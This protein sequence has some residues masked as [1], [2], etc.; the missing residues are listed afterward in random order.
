MIERLEIENFRGLDKLTIDGLAR[1][2][3]FVG[4]NNVG[5]SSVLEAVYLLHEL[6]VSNA[7]Q[8]VMQR[9]RYHATTDNLVPE[10][11][12]TQGSKKPMRFKATGGGKS[13][14]IVLKPERDGY[15]ATLAR[16]PALEQNVTAAYLV[17]A[18]MGDQQRHGR[19]PA[20]FFDFATL[21]DT[22]VAE[23]IGALIVKRRREKLVAALQRLDAR[24]VGI[25]QYK[26]PKTNSV[27]AWVDLGLPELLRLTQAGHGL[28][29]A[30]ALFTELD[31]ARDSIVL[32]DEFEV[33][34]H[35]DV[36]VPVW[37]TIDTLSREN[38][39]QL[40]VT[41]HSY[42]C[43]KAVHE[44][45]SSDSKDLAVFRLQRG[46]S[47]KVVAVKIDAKTLGGV[48]ALDLEVR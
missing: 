37:Q 12:Q 15:T 9:R 27:E 22:E 41:T 29:Y 44:A 4:A 25:D 21:Q 17:G 2:N 46:D 6:Q 42:E 5:K 28:R 11:F 20:V 32:I 38:K 30:A 24:V 48:I 34:L 18:S 40:F 13:W 16:E 8:T 1:V 36:I 35:H 43:L 10:I 47:G 7:V 26:L 3:V 39:L 19:V 45:M 14:Q 33:G 31:R 23:R